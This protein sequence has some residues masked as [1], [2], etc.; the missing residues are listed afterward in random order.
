[1]IR[2]LWK[3]NA[4]EGDIGKAFPK[5]WQEVVDTY[6]NPEALEG[7]L[8]AIKSHAKNQRLKL[9]FS[10]HLIQLQNLHT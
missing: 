7:V 1:M 5:A 4:G 8:V 2:T 3:R 10:F 9:C 6:G